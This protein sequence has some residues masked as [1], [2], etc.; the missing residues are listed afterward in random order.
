METV[1]V[2]AS[3]LRNFLDDI[4][5]FSAG[6]FD[7]FDRFIIAI[8]VTLLI[9]GIL[10]IQSADFREPEILIPVAWLM[11]AFFSYLGWMNIPLDTIPQIKG[12]PE[13]WLNKWNVFILI[14]LLGGAYLIKKH[15]R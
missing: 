11:V 15:L 14:S 8:L 9:V 1:F 2:G 10:S 4:T 6:A 3:S 13:N 5:N 7:D 12:L